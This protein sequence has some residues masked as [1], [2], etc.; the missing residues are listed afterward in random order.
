[1][2]SVGLLIPAKMLVNGDSIAY[3]EMDMVTYWHI[4]L[5]SH[6][7]LLAENMA[8]ESYL[9]MGENR[10]FFTAN[11][12]VEVPAVAFTR[13]HADFCLPFVAEGPVLE[14][15]KHSLVKARQTAR[16]AGQPYNERC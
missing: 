10:R 11:D 5:D 6:D 14:V 4:E 7:T 13:T 1:M 3:A 2:S 15:V 16:I 12:C 8:A 9:E